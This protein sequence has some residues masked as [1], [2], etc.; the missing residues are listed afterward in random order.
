M[1]LFPIFFIIFIWLYSKK[2]K[3]RDAKKGIK[4]QEPPERYTLQRMGLAS[5]DEAYYKWERKLRKQEQWRKYR[6]EKEKEY[7]RKGLK[8]P[9]RD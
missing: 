3:A 4:R 6:K 1:E 5:K 2:E 9:W 8:P 7:K